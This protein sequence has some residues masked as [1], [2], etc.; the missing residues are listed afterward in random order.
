MTTHD[1]PKR[2]RKSVLFWSMMGLA[3]GV[4]TVGV[5]WM[6]GQASV[7][8]EVPSGRSYARGPNESVRT[9]T[10]GDPR[11]EAVDVEGSAISPLLSDG[12]TV[13]FAVADG[14][15]P[16][17]TLYH[18]TPS[19]GTLTKVATLPSEGRMSG[20]TKVGDKIALANGERVSVIS[21]DGQ[22]VH[23][24]LPA[25]ERARDPQLAGRPQEIRAIVASD[26]SIYV[27][28]YN[29]QGVEVIDA[30]T[31]A[32]VGFLPLPSDLAPPATLKL[33]SS[34]DLIIGSPYEF[35]DLRGGAL[36]LSL[37]SSA[38]ERWPNVRPYS[39]ASFGDGWIATQTSVKEIVAV[40]G[41]GRF[42]P[43]GAY[44]PVTGKEDVLAANRTVVAVAPE[45]SGALF[46]S[47]Q[48]GQVERY[49]LPIFEGEP[50][51]PF[52]GDTTRPAKITFSSS[53]TSL[54][55]TVDGYV[56]LGTTGLRASLAVVA[57]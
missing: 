51:R 6:T 53:I 16:I 33:T 39:I 50:S 36:R 13:W 9:V 31:L 57:P 25:R 12:P 23:V 55:V 48:V 29:V 44:L 5:L 14:D 56:V 28:R 20:L 21:Q 4:L 3:T 40:D 24:V 26:K 8:T 18:L 2:Q 35:Y 45:G 22:V 10:A 11:L 54:A 42:Y 27:A 52:T 7:R 15:P 34:G 32:A 43:F 1:R 30:V 19:S 17:V 41:S 49:E 46:V 37:A 47:R 38:M